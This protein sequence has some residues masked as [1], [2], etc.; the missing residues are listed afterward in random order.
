MSFSFDILMCARVHFKF[1]CLP[2]ACEFTA[3]K[4]AP[5]DGA[6]GVKN[7]E[8]LE[9]IHQAESKNCRGII[10]LFVVVRFT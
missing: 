2:R 5:K 3:V 10:A 4:R 7:K 8:V 6:P 1:E 9:L